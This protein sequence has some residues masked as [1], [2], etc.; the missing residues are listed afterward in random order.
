MEARN[1][2]CKLAGNL[3][4]LCGFN[5]VGADRVDRHDA[6]G[7]YRLNDRR[8]VQYVHHPDIICHSCKDSAFWSLK[9]RKKKS[10]PQAHVTGAIFSRYDIILLSESLF[11]ASS[12]PRARPGRQSLY[13]DDPVR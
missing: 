8:M 5:I 7:W 6:G 2:S 13:T 4:Q 3:R 11:G 1:I 9:T 10:G 12:R